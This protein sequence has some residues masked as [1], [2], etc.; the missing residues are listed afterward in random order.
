MIS[1]ISEPM[2]AGGLDLNS[3]RPRHRLPDLKG[4]LCQDIGYPRYDYLS[5]IG[6]TYSDKETEG[7]R[8]ATGVSLSGGRVASTFFAVNHGNLSFM[9]KENFALLSTLGHFIS[10]PSTK[11]TQSI[12][13]QDII[14]S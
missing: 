11:L 14:G 2:N 12:V 6:L 8:R 3:Q 1:T 7:A 10:L 5:Y 13:I 9:K 4:K